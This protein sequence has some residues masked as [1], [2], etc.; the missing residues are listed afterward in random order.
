MGFAVA[1]SA[2]VARF[3]GHTIADLGGFQDLLAQ[4]YGARLGGK[5][6]NVT[7]QTIDGT[8]K[9][10][11]QIAD[12][13]TFGP[14][15]QAAKA[16]VDECLIEWGADSRAELAALVNRVF[17]V[18]R[19]GMIDKAGLFSLL[20]LDIA[21]ARWTRAMTA[22]RD[23]IRVTGSKSYIRFYR[24]ARAEA[25]WEPVTIDLAAA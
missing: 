25:A 14:E 15:L 4:E 2:R 24:R 5:K 21:D 8:M 18:E 7:F 16:L 13:I 12:Q 11:V 23:S 10:Q 6:G 3:K 1:L 19:E 9:V 17:N 20:R 22:I